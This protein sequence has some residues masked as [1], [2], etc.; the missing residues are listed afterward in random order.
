MKVR[1]LAFAGVRQIVGQSELE[2]E[3]PDGSRLEDLQRALG[4]RF[5]DLVDYWGRLAVAIDGELAGTGNALTDGAEIALLPPVSG[6]RGGAVGL[7]D[8]PIDAD[9]VTAS[10]AAPG[11]GAV[12][13]FSGT[14]RDH[15]QGRSVTHLTYDAYRPMAL[16]VLGRIVREIEDGD[17]EVTLAITHRL[18]EVPAGQPSVVI[19]AA[20]PHRESAYAA[21][22]Q[23]LERL[24]REVPIWKLEHYADGGET[25]REEEPLRA[26]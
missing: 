17:P 4:E 15:H 23:A 26:G 13:V 9:A 14:V 1:V 2:I 19:A 8:G 16:T 11:S 24:K 10:V 25:W 5:P 20:S 21:S 6:G 12:V 3:L 22:R 18:G 7:V